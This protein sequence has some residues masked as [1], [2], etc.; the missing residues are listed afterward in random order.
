ML[1]KY[2]TKLV[3]SILRNNEQSRDDIMIVIK[4]IHDFELS[5]L[6]K[7]TA[8][9]YDAFF[10]G[11]L[12]SVSTISRVWRKIQENMPDLRGKEWEL[13][14]IKAGEIKI[15]MIENQLKLF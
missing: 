5:V 14:Q 3:L 2:V 11:S 4:T 12:S 15:E 13:R 10:S 6:K 8:D 1:N 7:N 9:Y